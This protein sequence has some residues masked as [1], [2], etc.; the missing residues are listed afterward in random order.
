MGKPLKI[1]ITYC[2]AWG[3]GSKFQRIKVE[4]E[5]MY[6]DEISVEGYGTPGATGWLEVQIEGGKLLHSK[7]NGDGYVDTKQKMQN[8]IIG[9]AEALKA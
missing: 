9:V 3:Y 2:G 7:K 8:I 6:G 1:K 4:L 5:D